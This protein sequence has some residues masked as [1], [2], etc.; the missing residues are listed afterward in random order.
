MLCAVRDICSRICNVRQ[1]SRKAKWLAGDGGADAEDMPEGVRIQRLSSVQLAVQ[2]WDGYLFCLFV[3]AAVDD[4]KE[5][6]GLGFVCLS[7]QSIYCTVLPESIYRL[8]DNHRPSQLASRHLHST[9]RQLRSAL[10]FASAV[11]I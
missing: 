11:G 9:E 3:F 8:S 4:G 1:W 5:A 6:P 2:T 7:P 10:S